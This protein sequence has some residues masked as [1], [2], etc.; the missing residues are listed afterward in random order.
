[1][2][3]RSFLKYS[4]VGAVGT[5]AALYSLN[6]LNMIK[7]STF[8]DF[9]QKNQVAGQMPDSSAIP[10]LL[11]RAGFGA[12][13][14]ELAMYQRMGFETAVNNLVNYQTLDNS[15]VPARPNIV[16]S[17]TNSDYADLETVQWWWLN[18]MV[19][20]SRPLE[21]KMTLFWHNHFA[22]AFSKVENPYLMYVQNKFLRANALGNFKDLLMGITSDPAMLI[23]LDGNYNSKGNPNENYA[24]EIMEVFSTGRGPYTE[25][26]VKAGA[27]AFT[28]YAVNEDD[29]TSSFIPSR[30]D[31]GSKTYLGQTGNFGPEDI[32]NILV[33]HPATAANLATELFSY[34]AYPYPSKA[35]VDK[36]AQVYLDS[37]YSIKA[38][39]EAILKSD[40]FRSTG[41]YLAL[42]K[43]PVEFV[44]TALRSTRATSEQ[45]STLDSLSYMGQTL[46]D[47]PT[48][49]GWPSGM[50]WIDSAS[51]F[52]RY[53]FPLKMNT[54][55]EDGASRLDSGAVFPS[56][57]PSAAGVKALANTLFPDGLPPEYLNVVQNSVTNY[58]DPV[59]GTK[60]ALRLTMASPFYLLN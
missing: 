17:Y 60:D 8:T 29:G 15:V 54:T 49:F 23:W 20:T 31:F 56:G 25:V 50:A 45:G 26:D 52:E 43:S 16:L 4:M 36:F 37:K 55:Q 34:F 53:N 24:R 6:S 19:N 12:D 7:L 57:Q 18:R 48:V 22:T 32:V 5:A 39:V 40:E 46:L 30:H 3:R 13:P 42:V 9:L 1:M 44:A 58:N 51:I 2:D 14:N 59:A 41:S 10:H 38:I 28:G 35:T 11:R 33:P 47:P 21:E 27:R